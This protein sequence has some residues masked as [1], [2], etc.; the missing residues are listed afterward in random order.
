MD[1]RKG[2]VILLLC[3]ASLSTKAQTF[4]EWFN[5]KKTQT[6]YLIQQ[7]AELKV[8]AGVL[9]KG[10]TIARGGLQTINNIKHGDFNLHSDYFASLKNV[11]PAVRDALL[12]SD[13]M[14]Y[15]KQ[16]IGLCHSDHNL[17]T[18]DQP[19]SNI[20]AA[21]NSLDGILDQVNTSID[22]L[23][24]LVSSGR[25]S[26]KDDQRVSQLQALDLALADLYQYAQGFQLSTAQLIQQRKA[27]EGSLY[28]LKKL[29]GIK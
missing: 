26:M 16:L 6:K 19:E 21:K 7:I 18:T 12:V 14:L 29:N 9:N 8:Y 28:M 5:Q 2:T 22:M 13:I 23:T 15:Q 20:V 27:E 1:C 17:F 25:L 10:Y 4:G 3:V 24:L 11:P